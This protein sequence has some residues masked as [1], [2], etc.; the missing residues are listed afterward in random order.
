MFIKSHNRYI[1]SLG[2]QSKLL[3]SVGKWAHF[4]WWS[5]NLKLKFGIIKSK[6]LRSFSHISFER[7]ESKLIPNFPKWMDLTPRLKQELI[8]FGPFWNEFEKRQ[9]DLI[10]KRNS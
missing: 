8:S 5:T 4:A 1:W 3:F 2:S 6:S 10:N 7:E 9:C